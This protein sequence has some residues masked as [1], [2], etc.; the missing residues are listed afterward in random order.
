VEEPTERLESERDDHAPQPDGD[1]TEP[2]AADNVSQE[3]GDKASIDGRMSS[4]PPDYTREELED[5]PS[6]EDAEIQSGE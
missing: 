4:L 5:N 6:A 2:S 1:S 3:T